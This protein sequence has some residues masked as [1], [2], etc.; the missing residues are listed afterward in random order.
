MEMWWEVMTVSVG[1]FEDLQASQ[2][3]PVDRNPSLACDQCEEQHDWQDYWSPRMVDR[4]NDSTRPLL[5][6]DCVERAAE[7]HE[8]WANNHQLSEYVSSAPP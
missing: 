1:T 5:C 3:R 2:G 4:D 6:D 7:W 8:R